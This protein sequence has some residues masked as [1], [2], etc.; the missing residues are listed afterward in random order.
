MKR[1]L[2]RPLLCLRRVRSF[3]SVPAERG[4]VEDSRYAPGHV[5]KTFRYSS[6]IED[7]P[8][9]S[10]IIRMYDSKQIVSRHP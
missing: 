3:A 9:L 10:F 8:K 6:N 7:R 4:E 1:R 2:G 5:V